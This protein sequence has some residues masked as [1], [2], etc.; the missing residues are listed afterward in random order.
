MKRQHTILSITDEN[1][2]NYLSN[3][4]PL[5]SYYNSLN[6]KITDNLA[7]LGILG[8]DIDSKEAGEN[9]DA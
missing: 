6:T 1:L 9:K 7:V 3:E 4:T 2:K 8:I 5:Y